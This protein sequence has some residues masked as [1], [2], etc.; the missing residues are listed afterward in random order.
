MILIFRDD[1]ISDNSAARLTSDRANFRAERTNSE[2][3]REQQVFDGS[4][5]REEALANEAEHAK[6]VVRNFPL[7][8]S[9]YRK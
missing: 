2:N 3:L 9:V 5:T 4:R 7:T 1:Q 6:R 8:S